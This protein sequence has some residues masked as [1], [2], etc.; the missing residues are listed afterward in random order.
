[1]ILTIKIKDEEQ[2]F[3]I[4]DIKI[5][6][7]KR[8]LAYDSNIY[9]FDVKLR[10]NNKFKIVFECSSEKNAIKLKKELVKVYSIGL[11]E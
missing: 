2:P 5:W 1:M 4:K 3:E 9:C 6:I 8:K 11:E 7:K 10:L